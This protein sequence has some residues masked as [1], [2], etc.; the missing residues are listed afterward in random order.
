MLVPLAGRGACK[1]LY[2]VFP[3]VEVAGAAQGSPQAQ[4]SCQAAWRRSVRLE[5]DHGATGEAETED[6]RAP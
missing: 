5:H 6:G 3:A 4:R 2:G 1:A